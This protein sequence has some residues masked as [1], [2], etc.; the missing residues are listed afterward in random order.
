MD[1]LPTR[2][3]V[4]SAKAESKV[5]IN[6]TRRTQPP[7]RKPN[8]CVKHCQVMPTYKLYYF[9]ARGS[10]EVIRFVFAQA[11][12]QYEDIRLTSEKWA[13]F[14]PKT[15]YG[16]LPVL[17]ID[18]K[19]V[20]GSLPIARYLAKLHGLDGGDD[21]ARLI[22]EGAADAIGDFNKKLGALYFEKDEERKATLKKEMEETVMP[23]FL[24]A[25]EKLAASNTCAEGWFYGANVSYVDF[26][27]TNTIS[28]IQGV[29]PTVLDN[30]PALKKLTES[31]VKLPNIAK[32]IK[33]RPETPH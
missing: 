4:I 2:L 33:E 26:L 21:M 8:V 20:G 18:G 23:K 7:Q 24:G 29:A 25:M 13:E 31:V 12:V 19:I 32:W 17:D 15:P 9:D 28:Y 30:F 1:V 16:T 11:G 6:R 27:F 3:R 14:K 10:A 5:H 22:L